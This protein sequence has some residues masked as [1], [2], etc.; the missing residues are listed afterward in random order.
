M[1][2]PADRARD[3]LPSRPP[4]TPTGDV[5][6]FERAIRQHGGAMLAVA[7]RLLGNEADAHDCLQEAFLQAFDK[8]DS[9]QGRAALRTWLHRIVVNTALM[10]LRRRKRKNEQPID[11]LMPEYDANG[12]R[13]EPSWQAAGQLAESADSLIQRA[14]VRALVLN[15]IDRLPDS[16]RIVLVLR[17]I[18]EYNTDEVAKL[19]ETNPGA[20]KTRLHRAR[21]ALKKLLEPVFRGDVA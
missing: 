18:E 11:P 15:A 17:D 9:F 8:L 6:E 14:E 3:T 20:V 2:S 16:Y 5:A 4:A 13:L 7:R 21:A 12:C 19:L 1:D 10:T